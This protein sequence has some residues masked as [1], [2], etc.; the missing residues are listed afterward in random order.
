MSVE[1]EKKKP[2]KAPAKKTASAAPDGG[3]VEKKT[4]AAAPKPPAAK[5]KAPAKAVGDPAPSQ[6]VAAAAA[7]PKQRSQP[8]HAQVAERAYFLFLERGQQHGFHDQDWL[9]A[10]EEL[11]IEIL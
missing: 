9:R 8:T 3:P 4:N 7:E 5:K 1:D 6:P 11:L 10:Q 2:R